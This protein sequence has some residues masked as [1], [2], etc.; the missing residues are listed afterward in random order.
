[1]LLQWGVMVVLRFLI[2]RLFQTGTR[3]IVQAGMTYA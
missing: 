2:R 1:V 3:S